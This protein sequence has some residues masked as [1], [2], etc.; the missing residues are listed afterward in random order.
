MAEET[1]RLEEYKT[2]RD[3]TLRRIDARNQIMSY[4]LAFAAAMFTLGLGKD[5]FAAALLVY[6]IVAFFFA[7]SFSHSSLMLIQI[8]QYLR[9]LE[10]EVAGLAWATTLRTRYRTIE[11]FELVS[12]AGLFLGTQV[13]GIVFYHGLP[14]ASR[15]APVALLWAAVIAVLLTVVSCFFPWFHHRW[16]MRAG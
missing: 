12:T 14:A 13:I 1:A 8:G 3:E 11:L 5:G 9:G 7:T 16:V 15:T 4:T 2:L 10:G 6:P